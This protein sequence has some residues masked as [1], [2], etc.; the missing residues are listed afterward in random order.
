MCVGSA[1]MGPMFCER[2]L[3]PAEMQGFLFHTHKN[4]SIR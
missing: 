3:N 1:V 4:R 2:I